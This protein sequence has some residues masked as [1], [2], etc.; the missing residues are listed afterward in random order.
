MQVHP[1]VHIRSFMVEDHLLDLLE[2]ATGPMSF[3]LVVP[4]S[5]YLKAQR[6]RLFADSLYIRANLTLDNVHHVMM[7]GKEGQQCRPTRNVFGHSTSFILLQ[8]SAGA[9]RWPWNHDT[10][11]GRL[12]EA[13][14]GRSAPLRPEREAALGDQGFGVFSLFFRH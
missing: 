3:A 1:P 6:H 4:T 5:Q 2:L 8:N 10:D 12:C 9:C 11:A 7:E 14:K 13:F